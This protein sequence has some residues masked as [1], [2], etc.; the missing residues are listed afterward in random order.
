MESKETSQVGGEKIQILVGDSIVE[1]LIATEKCRLPV[2]L[3][4]EIFDADCKLALLEA[5]MSQK[6]VVELDASTQRGC[7]LVIDDIRDLLERVKNIH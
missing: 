1:S 6:K 5:V 4:D 7:V 3:R 2:G